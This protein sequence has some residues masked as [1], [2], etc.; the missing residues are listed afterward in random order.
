MTTQRQMILD[1]IRKTSIHPTADEVYEMVKKRMPRIS[2]GTVY[3][4]LE[5]LATQGMIR[6]LETVGNQKRFDGNPHPHH[7]VRCVRCGALEDV[8]IHPLPPLKEIL[9]DSKGYEIQGFNLEFTGLC[10]KC[11]CR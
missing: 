10:P 4:N 1:E 5:V 7:H 3:R 8:G 9:Y 2:L 6:R 11:K